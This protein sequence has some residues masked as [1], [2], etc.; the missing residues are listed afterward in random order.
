MNRQVN[1]RLSSPAEFAIRSFFWPIDI[2]G[3]SFAL[4]L[5][6]IL[7]FFLNTPALAQ[8]SH[9]LTFWSTNSHQPLK[10]VAIDTYD[11]TLVAAQVD[12]FIASLWTKGYAAAGV[13][14][15][16]GDSVNT[17]IFIYRGTRIKRVRLGL[18]VPSGNYQLPTAIKQKNLSLFSLFSTTDL[19]LSK[20]ENQ[21]YPFATLLFDSV[22]IEHNT[23]KGSLRLLPGTYVVFNTLIIKGKYRA[24]RNYLDYLLGIRPE[25]PYSERQVRQIGSTISQ[26]GYLTSI[27]PAE[28][29]FIPSKAR[30]Y[31]YLNQ[32]KANQV[33]ALIGL[34]GKETGGGVTFRGDATLK[35]VN[36]FNI[37]EQVQLQWKKLDTDEQRLEAEASFP[38]L[39]LGGFGS[40]GSLSIYRKDTSTLVVNPKIT[41]MWSGV[42]GHRLTGWFELKKVASSGTTT[43]AGYGNS[44]ST[45][46]GVGYSYYH[47]VANQFPSSEINIATGAALGS[48]LADYVT[49]SGETVAQAST[50]Y[51]LNA[52]L[53]VYHSIAGKLGL[54]CAYHG[55]AV[56]AFGGNGYNRLFYNELLRVGGYST[57][58][59]FDEDFFWVSSFHIATAE[60]RY[61]FERE[62]YGFLFIDKGYLERSWLNGFDTFKPTGVGIGTQLEVSGGLF[63]LAYALGSTNGGMP[64]FKDAKVHFGFTARF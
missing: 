53:G 8:G 52:K 5:I 39:G 33:S 45:F 26:L 36:T 38:W 6:A 31:V 2:Y 27:R 24:N 35:L 10:T 44:S 61:Y 19:L 59:G 50:A 14:S 54:Y 30:V 29:E 63:Q 1:S 47:L 37:G 16:H 62:S 48:R 60:V 4:S 18:I 41:L 51:S 23:L 46:Y 25:I 40:A 56:G 42:T 21:G 57:L 11:S 43:V 9:A 34:A 58:R 7:T 55:G 22:S 20:M 28:P 3:K 13:D 49:N 64:Q 12:R 32:K 17:N 15:I